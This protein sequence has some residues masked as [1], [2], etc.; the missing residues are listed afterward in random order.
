MTTYGTSTQLNPHTPTRLAVRTFLIGLG[1]DVATAVTVALAAALT[2]IRWTREYWTVVGLAV[3]KS[4]LTATVA[5]LVRR[6]VSPQAARAG[7]TWR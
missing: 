7:G 1:L 2:D 3:A 6:F 4:V 5:Y